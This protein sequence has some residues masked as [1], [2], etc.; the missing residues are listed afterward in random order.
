[1]NDKTVGNDALHPYHSFSG[2]PA[3]E[4]DPDLCIPI[5]SRLHY[6]TLQYMHAYIHIHTWTY[7]YT[8]CVYMH[9]YICMHTALCVHDY[10]PVYTYIP[11]ISS[12][13][14]KNLGLSYEPTQ[15]IELCA[16]EQATM[17][18]LPAGG[19]V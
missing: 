4:M 8:T 5:V 1:M 11:T 14:L 2:L 10:G 7:M 6:V 19:S 3:H 16:A 9:I 13:N 15:V 12:Y 18:N 17:S